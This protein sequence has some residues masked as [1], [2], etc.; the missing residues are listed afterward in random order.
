MNDAKFNHRDPETLPQS[1]R[2]E[3][4][5]KYVP[6]DV[7][8]SNWGN[9]LFLRLVAKKRKFVSVDFTYAI[10]DNCY[11]RDSRF[12]ECNFTG[13]KFVGCN[14]HGAVFDGCKFDYAIFERTIIDDAILDVGC[15]GAENLRMRF[16]RT[17]RVNYQQIGDAEGANKAIR[18]ELEATGTHLKK[19]WQSNESYYRRKYAGIN[20]VKM[21][22]RWVAFTAL[23]RV[24]GNGESLWRLSQFVG[25][26]LLGIAV[27]QLLFVDSATD[28]LGALAKSPQIFLGVDVPAQMPPSVQA[29]IV[30]LRLVT[31]GL[32]M[33]ILVKRFNRR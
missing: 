27:L 10:F 6:S 4:K 19:A 21:F 24:W 26:S 17:L 11:L 9:I 29:A 32:F 18:T 3:L 31:F 22:M 8:N 12:E 14:L 5:D 15:P 7:K 28:V 16:A 23:D 1:Q 2:A 13:S 33:A 20:R 25:V 30:F